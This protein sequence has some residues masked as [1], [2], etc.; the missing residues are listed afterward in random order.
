MSFREMMLSTK[1]CSFILV[2]FL[3]NCAQRLNIVSFHGT[4]F[5]FKFNFLITPSF[6]SSPASSLFFLVALCF[7]LF[8]LKLI[9]SPFPSPK[10]SFIRF[11]TT[12]SLIRSHF[13]TNSHFVSFHNDRSQFGEPLQEIRSYL[14]FV[15]LLFI[16]R[17]H[18]L[19]DRSHS[20]IS[21]Q[22]NLDGNEF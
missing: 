2:S 21:C 15:V 1:Y 11:H 16:S 20:F 10:I 14:Y 4:S 22:G 3:L 8:L 17:S 9:T 13:A 5:V 7:F 6:S 19:Q 18:C 12:T